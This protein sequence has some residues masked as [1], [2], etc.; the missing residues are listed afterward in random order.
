MD[1]TRIKIVYGDIT[2]K[3]LVR[4]GLVISDIRKIIGDKE[5]SFHYVDQD[6]DRIT[7]A[8]EQE[9]EDAIFI[10]RITKFEWRADSTQGDSLLESQSPC[11]SSSP[12]K[13]RRLAAD[14][15]SEQNNEDLFCAGKGEL[16][17][18]EG[19]SLL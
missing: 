17:E 14:N 18:A 3:L 4:K 16:G 5:F 19:G 1:T 10:D 12:N 6:G 9:M 13:V 8:S 7:A 2:R 11:Q 15:C